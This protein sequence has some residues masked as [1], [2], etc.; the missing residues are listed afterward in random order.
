MPQKVIRFKVKAKKNLPN[1]M[2]FGVQLRTKA[3]VFKNGKAYNRKQ[4]HKESE[5]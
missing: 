2:H 5:A 3:A 4:K 1:K